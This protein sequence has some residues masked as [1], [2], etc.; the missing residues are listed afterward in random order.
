MKELE[1]QLNSVIN[2]LNDSVRIYKLG[3]Y[4]KYDVRTL[5]KKEAVELSEPGAIM[6]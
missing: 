4:T 2:P 5:G 1:L 6:L 3:K